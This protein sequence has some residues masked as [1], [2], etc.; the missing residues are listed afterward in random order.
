ME[1]IRS[2][3]G[4]IY[5]SLYDILSIYSLIT[6]E[7]KVSCGQLHQ[8]FTHAIF[9]QKIGAKNSK[10][11]ISR[12]NFSKMLSYKKVV[13][14]TLMKLITGCFPLKL[15]IWVQ[16]LQSVSRIWFKFRLE[17]IDTTASAAS[18]KMLDLKVVKIYFQK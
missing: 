18:K 8:H 10:P 13:G 16:R 7:T 4:L 3:L 1:W 15:G 9:I 12:K 14:K 17:P 5:S 11:K 6:R 2:I